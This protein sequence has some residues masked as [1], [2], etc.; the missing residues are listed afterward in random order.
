M[1]RQIRSLEMRILLGCFIATHSP[2]TVLCFYAIINGLAGMETILIS[3]LV[4]TLVATVATI[5][6]VRRGF[7]QVTGMVNA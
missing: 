2:L 4:A 3:T 6:I 5:M 7:R 1:A